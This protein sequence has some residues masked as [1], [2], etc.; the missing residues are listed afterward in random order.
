[1]LLGHFPTEDGLQISIGTLSIGRG[2]CASPC[3]A[4]INQ[5]CAA[6]HQPYSCFT[7]KYLLLIECFFEA[8]YMFASAFMAHKYIYIYIY[9]DIV[10]IWRKEELNFIQKGALCASFLGHYIISCY[11]W[12]W[13]ASR[14]VTPWS[15]TYDYIIA[16]E[17]LFLYE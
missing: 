9:N 15:Y 16:Y 7:Q 5:S 13:A 1:M 10:R 11:I 8:L 4:N 17:Y 12:F 14:K 6:Y 3:D 2:P